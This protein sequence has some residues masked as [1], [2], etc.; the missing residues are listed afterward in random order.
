VGIIVAVIIH[1]LGH[2]ILTRVEGLTLKSMGVLLALVPIGAFAEPDE[3]ELFGVR[4]PSKEGE[5]PRLPPKKIAG[6]KERLRILSAGVAGN[7]AVGGL[8]L[9]LLFA[10]VVPGFAPAS[11]TELWVREADPASGLRAGDVVLLDGQPVLAGSDLDGLL[12][13]MAGR[14]AR[15]EALSGG[16]VTF[17]APGFEG[18]RLD[19][20]SPGGAAERAGLR[21][22]DTIFAMDGRETRSLRAFRE[23]MAATLPGQQVQ[24]ATGR[25]A[26]TVALG[27]R[28]LGGRTVG[29]LGVTG[30]QVVAGVVLDTFPAQGYLDAYASVPR[31]NPG[32]ALL[33]L[34]ALPFIGP[35]PGFTPFSEPASHFYAP[36]GWLAG[37]GAG[38]VY[39]ANLLLWV[40]WIN[41]IVGLFNCLPAVPLDGGHVFRE[42]VRKGLRRLRVEG[43]ERRERMSAAIVRAFA[44]FIFLSLFVSFLGPNLNFG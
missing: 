19:S 27:E 13:G 35:Q 1:E 28:E 29:F 16:S 30:V 12:A 32:E 3:E 44:L 17:T 43:E 18:V 39:L 4:K 36:T 42:L 40:G 38:A 11:P 23:F 33:L 9:V 31:R 5:P 20:V 37:L 21:A 8:C 26:F 34:M 22:G 24:V 41:V 2:A 25:G 15:L 10:L 14:T 6:P 7:F